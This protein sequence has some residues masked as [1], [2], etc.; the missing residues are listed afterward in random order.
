MIGYYSKWI[1][2]NPVLCGQS[3]AL[4][5]IPDR[6]RNDKGFSAWWRKSRITHEHGGL[7]TKVDEFSLYF[8]FSNGN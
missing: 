3:H 8:G 6:P 2:N 5:Q 4:S 1:G 7:G